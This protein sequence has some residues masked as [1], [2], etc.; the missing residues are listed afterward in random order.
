MLAGVVG[1]F[2]HP[3]IFHAIGLAPSGGPILSSLA[4]KESGKKDATKGG[5]HSPHLW[6]PPPAY[7]VETTAAHCT[8][9]RASLRLHPS[10]DLVC[11]PLAAALALTTQGASLQAAVAEAFFV[12][13]EQGA[14]MKKSY[15]VT[16]AVRKQQRS[17]KRSA[18]RLSGHGCTD[19]LAWQSKHTHPC[20]RHPPKG[21]GP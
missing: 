21:V 11:W 20:H 18:H 14:A 13:T 5:G 10:S 6:N 2:S 7:G 8:S 3:N 19:K 17:G 1:G 12:E 15:Q 4:K 9:C 16:Y